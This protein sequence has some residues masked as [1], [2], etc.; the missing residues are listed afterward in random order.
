M[1][2]KAFG[3]E[4]L[5][6]SLAVVPQLVRILR[7]AIIENRLCPGTRLTETEI[8]KLMGVSRQPVREA[9]IKLSDEGLL[10]VRPQRGTFVRPISLDALLDARFVREAIEADLVRLCAEERPAG[11]VDELRRQ[12]AAQ[13]AL[14]A[15]SSAEFLPLDNL[16]HRSMAE[17][18]GRPRAWTMIAGLNRQ[19]DR[20]RYLAATHFPIGTL[21][22]QHEGIVDSIEAG[23]AAEAEAQMRHHLRMILSD[24]PAIREAAPAC[25]DGPAPATS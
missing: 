22:D 15:G 24:L 11:L 4:S 23:R 13:R 1:D 8:G 14:G 6:P 18:A 25:F 7:A 10:D 12:V 5:D 2:H 3:A 20:I 9:F 19:M 16:F 21:V 17:A